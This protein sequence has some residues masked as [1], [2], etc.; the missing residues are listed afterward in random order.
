MRNK[1]ALLAVALAFAFPAFADNPVT[2]KTLVTK[3]LPKPVPKNP[4]KQ[5]NPPHDC[6]RPRPPH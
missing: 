3:Q 5:P 6:L 4:C 1:G 2:S